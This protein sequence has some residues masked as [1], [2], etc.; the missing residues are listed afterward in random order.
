MKLIWSFSSA[1]MA[2]AL[3]ATPSLAQTVITSPT[4]GE[5]V[6]SPFTLNMTATSCSSKPVTA[7][8]YSLDSSS[9]T[10]SWPATYING[11]VGAPSGA[12]T[13]HVKVWNGAGGVCVTD[14]AINVTAA[15]AASNSANGSSVVP[16]DAVSVSAIQSLGNWI[17]IHDG[18][19]SGSSNGTMSLVAT[20][21]L[22]GTSRLFANQ[23]ND[24][25]GQ[26]YSVQFDDN[27]TAQNF[28]YDGWVY[29]AGSTS[30]FAN[31]EFDLD[32]TM[33]NGQT[34]IMGF[35]CDSWIH[36][37]DYAVNS[38]SPASPN[39][40]W[41]H[42]YAACNVQSWAVNQWHHV[43][44]YFSHD[45]SGNVTYHSVWL[46]GAEQD[47]NLTV[48]SGYELGWGPAIVTNFQID[49]N[50]SGTTW[51]NVYLDELTVYRW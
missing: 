51:G 40:T 5:Q 36:R 16:P 28:F 31:L 50:S 20:P 29:I 6:S 18:G 35:Q 17:T 12:H 46:D 15:A 49:G 37:W 30:G 9:S 25:G 34:V 4:N 42:S 48:F 23:F 27:T 45:E 22:T 8:G 32:Q 13:L 26:R 39:D 24:F 11:P 33:P 47:L 41:L 1:C 44:I 43:Q 2:L 19:T 3:A 10:S 21:T 7:V 38:G 14:V